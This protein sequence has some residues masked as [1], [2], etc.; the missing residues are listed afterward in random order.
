MHLGGGGMRCGPGC[1]GGRGGTGG[2]SGGGMGDAGGG[3]GGSGGGMGGGL[4]GW[5][6]FMSAPRAECS[7]HRRKA[8]RRHAGP[9]FKGADS[10]P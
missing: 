9:N 6:P 2:G 8:D 1:G 10:E 5:N 4:G 3:M 7:D